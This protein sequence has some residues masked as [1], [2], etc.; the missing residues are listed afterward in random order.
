MKIAIIG[1]GFVGNAL[2]NALN[3][4]VKIAKIDPRLNTSVEDL[5]DFGPEITFISVPTPMANELQDLSILEE[6]TEQIESID[7]DSLLV[8][9]STVLPNAISDLEKRFK[10]FIYN[11]EFL[12]EKNADNDFIRSPFIL[13][14]GS[15]K[16]SKILSSFYKKHTKCE[17][18]NHL[19]VD[20][21]SASLIKYSINTYLATKVVFFN[22]LFD[23]FSASGSHE[24]WKTFTDAISNDKRIGSS[25]MMVPGHDGRKGFGGACFPKDSYAL[26]K[27][28]KL[29]NVEFSLLK[30]VIDINNKIRLSYNDLSEREKNQNIDYDIN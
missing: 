21:I 24:D 18:E 22:Q 25:H 23:I 1:M 4:D 27:Y 17:T 13:F 6:V 15:D 9:K 3:E 2:L 12:T 7:L 30:N 5:L 19:F 14:G 26:Y 11:P 8:L 10:R 16:E 20:A 28:S 29:L